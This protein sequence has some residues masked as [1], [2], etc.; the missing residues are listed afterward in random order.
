M[1]TP[2]FL[3]EDDPSKPMH[4]CIPIVKIHIFSAVQ[5]TAR[6]NADEA[7][8]HVHQFTADA[9]LNASFPNLPIMTVHAYCPKSYFHEGNHINPSTFCSFYRL[10]IT[11]QIDHNIFEQEGMD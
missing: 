8:D 3:I 2:D 10:T 5:T 4:V 9:L 7:D 1:Q 11:S 6:G